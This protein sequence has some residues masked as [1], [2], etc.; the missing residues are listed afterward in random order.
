M[1]S[2]HKRM[3]KL[4]EIYS[5]RLKTFDNLIKCIFVL[6]MDETNQSESYFQ[7]EM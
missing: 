4:I 1:Q 6:N 5:K 2:I 7:M 3:E